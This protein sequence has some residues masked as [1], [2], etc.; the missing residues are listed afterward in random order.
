M[1]AMPGIVVRVID[2]P[3]SAIVAS[4]RE[5]QDYADK[6]IAASLSRNSAIFWA[7]DGASSQPATRLAAKPGS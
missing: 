4:P 7:R 2:S 3:P 1:A 6:P 5:A